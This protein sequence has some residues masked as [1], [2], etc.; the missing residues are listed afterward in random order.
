V[1]PRAKPTPE[2][3]LPEA[4]CQAIRKAS[5]IDPGGCHRLSLAVF[6]ET[7][8]F[9]SFSLRTYCCAARS[10]RHC[11]LGAEYALRVVA[12]WQ[13]GGPGPRTGARRTETATAAPASRLRLAFTV[14]RLRYFSFLGWGIMAETYAD[15]TLQEHA[16]RRNL[17]R[18]WHLT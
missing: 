17:G 16:S 12:L 4:G 18:R 14:S 3:R 15:P 13:F 9:L 1:T 6:G 7:G 8:R 5:A 11:A 10:I 2:N